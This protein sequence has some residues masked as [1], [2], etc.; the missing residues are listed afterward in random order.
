MR[1]RQYDYLRDKENVF[2]SAN[3]CSVRLSIFTNTGYQVKPGDGLMLNHTISEYT[4]FINKIDHLANQLKK[5]D[6]TLFYANGLFL[7][8]GSD[9]QHNFNKA[10]IE[11]VQKEEERKKTD[12]K[13]KCERENDL[14]KILVGYTTFA[15]HIHLEMNFPIV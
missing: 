5:Q 7:K 12:E 9:F 3:E 10:K 8:Q 1:S 11:S 6:C 15:W 4:K 14:K 2:S 13:Q